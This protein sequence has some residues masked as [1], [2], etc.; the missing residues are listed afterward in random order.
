MSREKHVDASVLDK[1]KYLDVVFG[2]YMRGD[3]KVALEDLYCPLAKK[4]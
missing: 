4:E 2:D 1:V 3:L